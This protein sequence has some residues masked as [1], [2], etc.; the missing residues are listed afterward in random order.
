M[1]NKPTAVNA[2]TV[3]K[4][5]ALSL[6]LGGSGVGY[7]Y[8][9]DQIQGLGKQREANDAKAYEL[10]RRAENLKVRLAGATSRARLE[11]AGRRFQLS[12]R[13]P[14]PDQVITLSEPP[15]A[16]RPA[17]VSLARQP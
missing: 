10:T 8:Q 6:F 12:L 11:L 2:T 14:E 13:K 17:H 1:A 16:V 15:V 5:L 4:V 3:A 9:K 7:V